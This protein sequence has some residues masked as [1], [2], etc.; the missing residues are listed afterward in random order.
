MS[1]GTYLFVI[2]L[3]ISW[4]ACVIIPSI[5]IDNECSLIIIA[6]VR[7]GWLDDRHAACLC[8]WTI[9]LALCS[10]EELV[11]STFWKICGNV[12][13]PAPIV[14]RCVLLNFIVQ[15][16]VTKWTENE[17]I[18][19]HNVW[20]IDWSPSLCHAVSIVSIFLFTS[21]SIIVIQ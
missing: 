3:L 8:N 9:Q 6:C 4:E 15:F 2:R 12:V 17:C 11:W 16:F 20:F 19:L 7:A 1:S 13:W 10:C 21:S 14:Y 18:S 5:F